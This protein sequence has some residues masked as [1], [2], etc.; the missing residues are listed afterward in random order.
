MSRFKLPV[1]GKRKQQDRGTHTIRVIRLAIALSQRAYK[2][3]ELA[4]KFSAHDRT[5]SRD[6]HIMDASG[7]PVIAEEGCRYRVDAHFMRRFL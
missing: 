3:Q 5:I 1:D 4:E 7:I 2:V 6:L